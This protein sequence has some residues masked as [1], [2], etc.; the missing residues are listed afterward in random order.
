MSNNNQYIM[1]RIALLV[2]LGFMVACQQIET[3][4]KIRVILDTDANNELDDQHAI[5]YLLFNSDV[6]EVEGITVNAT[7][8]GGGIDQHMDEAKRIVQLCGY[9]GKIPIIPGVNHEPY[10]S[11]KHLVHAENFSGYQAVD[12]IIEKALADTSRQ[13]VLIP[14]GSLT[15]IALA[16]KKEPSI[17]PH[18]KVVWL[19]ANWP[20]PGEYNLDNDTTAVNPLLDFEGLDFEICTVRYGKPSGTAAVGQSVEEIKRKMPGLGPKVDPPIEGRSGGAFS[21]FG[22]YSIELFEKIGNEWRALFDVCAVAIVKNP[23]WAEKLTVPAPKLVENGWENRDNNSREVTFWENFDTEAILTDFFET[24][25][26]PAKA[27]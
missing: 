9:D 12:F 10:D 16:L 15:N 24:M 4:Q 7:Y 1:H 14:V 25:K 2:V 21:C 19:G 11:L 27:N 17:A 18:I 6:F 3:N 5:A 23:S 13:L 22:D 8:N 20:D 26:S